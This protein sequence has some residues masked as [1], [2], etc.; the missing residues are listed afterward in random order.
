MHVQRIAIL[1]LQ[2]E[3]KVDMEYYLHKF[4]PIVCMYIHYI[5]NIINYHNI[6]TDIVLLIYYTK[7]KIKTI[8]INIRKPYCTKFW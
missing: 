7:E 6:Y 1:N 2:V 3:L 4:V 8:S 5:I